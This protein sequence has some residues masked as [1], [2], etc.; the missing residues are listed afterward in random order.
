MAE[1]NSDTVQVRHEIKGIG[2]AV[3]RERYLDTCRALQEVK[4]SAQEKYV[5]RSG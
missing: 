2:L 4:Y 3:V 5:L 1:T